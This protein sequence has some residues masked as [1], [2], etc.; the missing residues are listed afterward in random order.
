[1]EISELKNA[2]TEIKRKIP[3]GELNSR[4]T[5]TVRRVGKLK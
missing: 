5:I 1:M 2:I 3:L 4:V